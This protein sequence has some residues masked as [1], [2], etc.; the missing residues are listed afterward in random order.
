LQ[1]LKFGIT[2]AFNRNSQKG[3]AANSGPKKAVAHRQLT[4]PASRSLLSAT[5]PDPAQG[6][7][8]KTNGGCKGDLL[9]M[10]FVSHL[11]VPPASSWSARAGRKTVK[12]QLD[13]RIMK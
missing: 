6:I 11:P 12:R 3:V 8:N 10:E 5:R 13:E 7:Q 9:E 4:R 1:L 2:I